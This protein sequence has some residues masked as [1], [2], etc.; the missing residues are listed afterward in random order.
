MALDAMTEA[1]AVAHWGVVPQ[2]GGELHKFSVALGVELKLVCVVGKE[3]E[4]ADVQFRNFEAER[5]FPMLFNV[6]VGFVGSL[7]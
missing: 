2:C 4:I 7:L 6:V 3:V 1:S 5:F